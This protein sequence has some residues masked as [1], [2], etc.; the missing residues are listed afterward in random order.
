MEPITESFSIMAV[1]ACS[2]LC[3][4]NA[5]LPC[6]RD[7]VLDLQAWSMNGTT[8]SQP[9]RTGVFASTEPGDDDNDEPKLLAE[10]SASQAQQAW[11]LC[12]PLHGQPEL[13]Q[14]VVTAAEMLPPLLLRVIF[15]ILNQDRGCN[16]AAAGACHTDWQ[17]R[18]PVIPGKLA[19]RQQTRSLHFAA[20][21]VPVSCASNVFQFK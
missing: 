21:R 13:R 18:G 6:Q 5:T 17:F 8:G 20:H 19:G 16:A 12:R 7:C 10:L 2:S 11:Q 1:L 9:L 3:G 14:H 4:R 15:W